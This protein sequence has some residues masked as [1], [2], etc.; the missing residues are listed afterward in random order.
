MRSHTAFLIFGCVLLLL[1]LALHAILLAMPYHAQAADIGVHLANKTDLGTYIAFYPNMDARY[2]FWRLCMVMYGDTACYNFGLQEDVNSSTMEA[3]AWVIVCQAL[4]IAGL[5]VSVLS[6]VFC[7]MWLCLTSIHLLVIGSASAIIGGIIIIVANIVFATEKSMLF[8]FKS[9]QMTN[10]FGHQEDKY[11]ITTNNSF[12]YGWGFGVDIAT[13]GVSVLVGILFALLAGT[14]KR[15]SVLISKYE[16]NMR[17]VDIPL[18]LG[19]IK[20]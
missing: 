13:G 4:S 6:V 20:K 1:T 2:G 15:D 12:D 19:N 11:L 14:I 3:P 7:L 16:M 5:G 8:V 9:N 17:G 18:Q 10:I